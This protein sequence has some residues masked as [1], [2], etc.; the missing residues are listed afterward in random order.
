MQFHWMQFYCIRIRYSIEPKD[1]I[2]AKEYGFLS[3]VKNMGKNLSNKYSRKL[4]DSAEKSTMDAIKTAS[5]G[6]I[7]KIAE[8]T[9][10]LIGTE[11]LT[12]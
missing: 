6:A 8:A 1:R 9:D 3:F 4:L 2:Y 10:D 5:K 12:K 7:Q 11:L